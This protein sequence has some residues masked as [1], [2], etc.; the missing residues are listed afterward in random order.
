MQKV[1]INCGEKV[2][3]WAF[4]SEPLATSPQVAAKANPI[5]G[6]VVGEDGKEVAVSMVQMV[7]KFEKS[8]KVTP[9]DFLFLKLYSLFYPMS[10]GAPGRPLHAP[11]VIRHL[12]GYSMF[13][14][15]HKVT[16]NFYNCTRFLE[17]IFRTRKNTPQKIYG[18]NVHLMSS[19]PPNPKGALIIR[20]MKGRVS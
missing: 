6:T 12:P 16:I 20:F 1:K 3:A 7:Q 18:I 5:T 10:A 15:T 9:L 4:K 8:C 17:N 11:L 2:S 13:Y 14:I 19:G